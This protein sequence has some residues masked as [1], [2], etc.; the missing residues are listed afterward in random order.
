MAAVDY[1]LKVQG[2]E[3]ES[4]DAKHKGEIDLE[5]WS[6]GAASTGPVE[7]GGGGGAGKVSIQDFHFVSKVSRASP[8]LFL[9]CASGQ[10]IKE[11]KM[12]G[13]K[14][15]AKEA[16]F[17]TLTFSDVL[18]STYQ[19]GGSTHSDIVPMDQVSLNF[20]KI[21]IEYRPQKADGSLDAPIRAGWDVKK[22]VKF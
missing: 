5:S 15:G 20:A 13:R 19:T 14:A 9:A 7:H 2:I 6:W 1:F 4:V 11:A 12:T 21:L 22:N 10:H 16:E 18:V 17:L 8:R 3:G